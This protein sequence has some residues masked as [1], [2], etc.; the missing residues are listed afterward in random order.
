MVVDSLFHN[1]VAVQMRASGDVGYIYITSIATR[2]PRRQ[3]ASLPEAAMLHLPVRGKL[4]LYRLELAAQAMI[5]GALP[6]MN[7]PAVADR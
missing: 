3:V 4:K 7:R 6:D 5:R 1:G 2:F